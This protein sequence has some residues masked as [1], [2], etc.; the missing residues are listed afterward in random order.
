MFS[1]LFVSANT[2]HLQL[3]GFLYLKGQCVIFLKLNNRLVAKIEANKLT[4]FEKNILPQIFILARLEYL[5]SG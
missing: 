5:I 2:N 1:G 3:S 4:K